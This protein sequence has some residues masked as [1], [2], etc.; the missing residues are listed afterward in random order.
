MPMPIDEKIQRLMEEKRRET[1]AKRAEALQRV[2]AESSRKG[3]IGN[4]VIHD[5][6]IVNKLKPREGS[7][8][9][10]MQDTVQAML[11]A[12]AV[13]KGDDGGSRRVNMG[14]IME[15]M[16][17]RDMMKPQ[18][19]N[20]TELYMLQMMGSGKE[21]P[22]EFEN[23]LR[24]QQENQ[25]ETVAM[26]KEMFAGKRTE[27]AIKESLEASDKKH[28]DLIGTILAQNEE[29]RKEREKSAVDEALDKMLATTEAMKQNYSQILGYIQQGESAHPDSLEAY[30]AN[31]VKDRLK[32]QVLDSIDKGLFNK[33]Q[34]VTPEGK[35]DWKGILDRMMNIGEEVVKKMP[36][37]A[38]PVQPIRV[39]SGQL[40]NPATGQVLPIEQ[41][42]PQPQIMIVEGTPPPQQPAQIQ[43]MP[44]PT[45]QTDEQQR[46]R[47]AGE[48]IDLFMRTEGG[49]ETEP[50]QQ[51]SGNEQY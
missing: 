40:V 25:K 14:E 43:I 29:M 9:E 21:V 8:A 20:M 28:Q 48:A 44:Q 23:L 17:V 5:L 41:A 12:K 42:Q 3:D 36:T 2:L 33:Q 49:E 4:D 22:K 10:K 7:A 16:M 46:K 26:L 37:H 35:F 45:P 50:A 13:G 30:I 51:P 18:Q 19:M 1:A 47:K 34:I 6:E 11:L 39:S 32:E 27:D 31:A 15:F 38:P 24:Q